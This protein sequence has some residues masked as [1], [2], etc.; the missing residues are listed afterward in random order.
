MKITLQLRPSDPIKCDHALIKDS[1]GKRVLEVTTINELLTGD[2]MTM[3]G[4]ALQARVLV[5]NAPVTSVD[6]LAK[7]EDFIESREF[8]TVKAVA[9]EAVKA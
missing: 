4:L 2:P 3:S 5:L 7:L 8:S 1:A 6:M 9:V